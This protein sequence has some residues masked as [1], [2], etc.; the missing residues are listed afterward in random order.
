VELLLRHRN[1]RLLWLAGLISFTGNFAFVIALPLHIYRMTGSTLATAGV[2][3]A[4]FLPRILFGSVAGVFVDR[5]DRKRTMVTADLACALLLLPI[6]LA[7]DTLPVLYAIAAAQASLR[8]FF[9]P[10]E[11]ALL[12]LL[13]GEDKLVT[14]NA[15]NS[16]ND[17]FALLLGPAIG[18][19]LYAR[20]GIEGA[21]LF[22][23]GSFVI[24]A[25]LISRISANARPARE[26]RTH[27]SG[28]AVGDM[29]SDLR[30]GVGVVRRDRALRVV[31]IASA[32]EG[33]SEGVF[34]TLGLSP[35]V[36]DVL[37]GTPEQVGWITGS[38]AVGGLIAGLVV[39]R[40]GSRITKRWL[41]GGGFIGVGLADL[42]TFN[43]Y[44]IASPGTPAVGAAMGFMA[45]AG[46]PAV[47]GMTGRRALL[48]SQT[49]DAFRGRVFGA[50]GTAAALATL[51]GIAIGGVLG[52]AVGIVPV[53]SA[54][55]LIRIVGGV[56]AF[57]YLPRHDTP[58]Q[59]ASSIPLSANPS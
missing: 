49:S 37:G 31:F 41:V 21:I 50:F 14:A 48:Q 56:V 10:A 22:D 12:P 27:A 25:A 40:I 52:D 51:L 29:L 19:L 53:L 42:S 55:A 17:N 7:P 13:V 2:F 44:R 30:E 38:Q 11:N 57:A 5:W 33:I 36:L 16:L 23:I 3:A 8:L 43:A 46:F 54:S 32:L 4:S 1:F 45:V 39:V 18:A 26:P 24:S 6:V 9:T 35:L 20:I 15:L 28:S 59:T 47:A 34:L 58:R